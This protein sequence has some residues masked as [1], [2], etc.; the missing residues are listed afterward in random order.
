M[1]HKTL[2]SSFNSYNTGYILWLLEQW[3]LVSDSSDVADVVVGIVVKV[4]FAMCNF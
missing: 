1:R 2:R 3:D 4:S